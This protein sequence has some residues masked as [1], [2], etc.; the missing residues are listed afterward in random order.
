MHRQPNF[1]IYDKNGHQ[2]MSGD[3]GQGV[4]SL[5]VPPRPFVSS[6][7]TCSRGGER[8]NERASCWQS[9]VISSERLERTFADR[10]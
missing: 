5:K 10:S 4:T 6:R 1:E 7:G 8:G 9:L 2:S 3:P